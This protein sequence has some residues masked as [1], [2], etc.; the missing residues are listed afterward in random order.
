MHQGDINTV[1][2]Q[3]LVLPGQLLWSFLRAHFLYLFSM[4][5]ISSCNIPAIRHH[6]LPLGA[7]QGTPACASL[8]PAVISCPLGSPGAWLSPALGAR[9]AAREVQSPCMH[10]THTVHSTPPIHSTHIMHSTHTQFC[11]LVSPAIKKSELRYAQQ[12]PTWGPSSHGIK[13]TRDAPGQRCPGGTAEAWCGSGTP[14][15]GLLPALDL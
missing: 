9:D 2:G 15:G 14:W 7:Q 10:S 11:H 4:R 12:S 6:W 8:G 5:F 1:L 3:G 13:G